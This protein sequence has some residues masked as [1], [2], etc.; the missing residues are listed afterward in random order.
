MTAKRRHA[1]DIGPWRNRKAP[2][3]SRC[4]RC[5]DRS[6]HSYRRKRCDSWWESRKSNRFGDTSPVNLH[7]NA[8]LLPFAIFGSTIIQHRLNILPNDIS[9]SK[10]CVISRTCTKN[11]SSMWSTITFI[12]WHATTPTN[13]FVI[14]RCSLYCYYFIFVIIAIK[15]VTVKRSKNKWIIARL[16]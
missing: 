14:D 4:L 5:K 15:Y 10:L 9:I 6:R 2:V 13:L 1:I 11:S 12:N 8:K 3:R 16:H 7:N